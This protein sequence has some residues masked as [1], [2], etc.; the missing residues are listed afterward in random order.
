MIYNYTVKYN[1]V[2]YPTGADVP[3][4]DT[5][6]KEVIEEP[7]I[8]TVKEAVKAKPVVHQTKVTPKRK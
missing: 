6:I 2:Y 4:E 7:K 8:E 1:G 5:P 3:V